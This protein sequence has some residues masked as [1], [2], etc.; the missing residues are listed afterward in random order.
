M[1]TPRGA[2]IGLF[3]MTLL[4]APFSSQAQDILVGIAV[5]ATQRVS[6]SQIDH[7]PWNAL[8]QDYVTGEGQV[9][10]RGWKASPE[11]LTQLDSYLVALSA[12]DLSA[13][14]TQEQ[15]LAYWINAYNAVT[16]KGILRE[17]PTTSIR[18]HTPKLWGYHI[19]KNLKLQAGGKPINLNDIEHEV[20]RKMG[21]P[22]VHFAIVCASIGCPRLL[23]EAYT[24]EKLE[25]QLDHNARHFFAQSQ[26]FR[27]DTPANTVHLSA[28]LKWFATDF[29]SDQAAQLRQFSVWLPDD[30]ARAFLAQPGI[31]VRHQ[32]YDWGLN[33]Q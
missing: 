23:N 14:A 30:D 12:V 21:D 19:W 16:I 33:G 22:R 25:E 4:S 11:S 32:K 9:N 5:P 15:K 13:P 26:N 6:F 3:L 18:N 2:T 24:P 7:T 17:Y 10:Y 31:K 28:I 1:T 29:G 20:L 27:I 8:L